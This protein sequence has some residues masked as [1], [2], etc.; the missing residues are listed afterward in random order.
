MLC[1]L[2]RGYNVIRITYIYIAYM[3]SLLASMT[4]HNLFHISFL[5]KCILDA[6]HVI[7][8]NVIQVE[9][10]GVLQVHLVRILDWKIK[11]LWN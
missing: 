5:K 2:Y 3:L 6:N 9:Q 7:D 8:W 4:V 1:I 10:E 11:H